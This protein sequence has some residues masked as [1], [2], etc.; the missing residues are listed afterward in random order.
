LHGG[1][2]FDFPDDWDVTKPYRDAGFVV[3]AL[4][5]RGENGQ[6]GYF[7]YFYDEV[8]D[9]LAAAES[10]SKQPFVDPNRLYLAG[11][12]A[13]GTMT[14]LAAMASKRFRAA[15]ALSG[16]PD[17]MGGFRTTT[18]LPFDKSD[19][20][21]LQLRSPMAYATSFKCPLRIYS[22][23]K[24]IAFHLMSSRTAALAKGRGL[25]VEALQVEG[26]HTTM[27]LPAIKQ[28]IAFFL[29]NPAQES[30]ANGEI[31]PLPRTLELDLGDEV[32]MKVAR[33]EPG[34]FSMG[35][36]PNELERRDDELQHEV[37]ITKAYCMGVYLVTQ[38]QYRQVMGMNPSMFSPR[39]RLKDKVV[40]L[41]TDDF[42]VESVSWEDAMDFC[43]M[44]S[45]LPDVKGKGWVVDLPT[46]AQ[47]EY[48][49]RAGTNT[50][51]HHGNSL[52][53]EQANFNGKS[54]YGGAAKGPFLGRPTKVGSYEA[55]AWGL[56]DMH[57]NVNQWCKDWYDKDY[58]KN[59]EK[60]DPVGP[61]DGQSRVMRGGPWYA[62]AGLC[63]AASRNPNEP[64][65]RQPHRGFR[66]VVRSLTRTP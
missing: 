23:T 11:H 5:L 45:L 34:R 51:F 42:P 17:Q 9:V 49:C 24:E 50:E 54:P 61:K 52:S 10:L 44:V 53:S 7:S 40:G 4:T 13:G 48:A 59:S 14:L 62:N 47:W 60:H 2:A 16:C 3:L 38:A 37:K 63:R 20:R 15:A 6:P 35:S 22:G 36:S 32:K 21:E 57:G 66:V 58:Y 64:E 26:N 31:A 19:P 29:R 33:V 30:V 43:R 25:D 41:A 46:E 56:F 39:G 1:F 55:N 27:L 12:S 28:S 8:D 18:G 65:P